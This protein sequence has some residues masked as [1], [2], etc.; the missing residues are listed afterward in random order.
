MYKNKK[1]KRK[2]YFKIPS[3]FSSVQFFT[4]SDNNVHVPSLKTRKISPVLNAGNVNILKKDMEVILSQPN[5]ISKHKCA[6]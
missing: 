1:K 3:R 5:I 4:S 2:I 6:I